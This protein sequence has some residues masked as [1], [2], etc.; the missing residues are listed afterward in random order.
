[1]ESI[2]FKAASALYALSVV[3]A[4]AYLYSRDEAITRWTWNLLGVALLLHLASFGLRAG[5]FWAFP[6]NR[7][8][9]PVVGFHGPLS[10]L[11][12]VNALIFWYVEGFSRLHILGAFVLPWTLL[13]AGLALTRAEPAAAPLEPALRSVW[14]NLHPVILITCYA[15][16]ANAFGVGLAF[17][18]QEAQIRS[19]KPTELCYRLPSL[20]ELDRL[21]FRIIA[22]FLPVLTVGILLGGVW[23]RQTWGSFWRWEGKETLALITWALYAAY[24]LLRRGGLRGRR[25]VYLSMAGFAS[26]LATFFGVS[27]FYSARG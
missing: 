3:L 16:F 20:E 27:H 22:V 14:L 10:W 24:L 12:L 17:L 2:L 25:G 6:E 1:M 4:L 11:A 26:V 8:L 9:L 13:S 7:W 23:A 19:R 18:V 15:A 5:S 21:V